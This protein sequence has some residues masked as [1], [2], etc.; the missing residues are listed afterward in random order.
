MLGESARCLFGA[1]RRMVPF[2]CIRRGGGGAVRA[3]GNFDYTHLHTS[4]T[5]PLSPRLY[6]H[7]AVCVFVCLYVFVCICTCLWRL[8][9]LT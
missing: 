2:R 4:S 8:Q 1:K 7:L 9:T 5:P 3:T 6:I